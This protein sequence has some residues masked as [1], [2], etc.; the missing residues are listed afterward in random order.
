MALLV[1]LPGFSSRF[2]SESNMEQFEGFK[3]Y[4]AYRHVIEIAYDCVI[5]AKCSIFVLG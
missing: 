2:C 1:I 4:F 3:Y 5:I